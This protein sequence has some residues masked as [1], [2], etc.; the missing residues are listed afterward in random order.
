MGVLKI[1][2]LLVHS[3][4]KPV[5]SYTLDMVPDTFRKFN[6]I[7]NIVAMSISSALGLGRLIRHETWIVGANN[8]ILDAYLDACLFP[9]SSALVSNFFISSFQLLSF[10]PSASQAFLLL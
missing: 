10:A 1:T 8:T 7:D 2:S 4:I 6:I 9:S 3:S 5:S